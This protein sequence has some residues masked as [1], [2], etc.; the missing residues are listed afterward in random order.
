MKVLI[1]I[2]QDRCV[3]VVR[4]EELEPNAVELGDNPVSTPVPGLALPVERAERLVKNCPS[5][6]ISVA[7]PAP[8]D[9]PVAEAG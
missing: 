4:C 2:D 9:T 5:G 6:A 1:A 8:D 7:G 3:G